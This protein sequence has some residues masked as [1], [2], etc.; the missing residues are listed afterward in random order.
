MR[1]QWFLAKYT[2]QSC[3]GAAEAITVAPYFPETIDSNMPSK[4]SP[5]ALRVVPADA[6]L[7][8][9]QQK[10]FNTLVEGIAKQRALLRDWEAAAL[11]FGHRYIAEMRP[12]AEHEQALKLQ[13]L[14]LLDRGAEQ[15]LAKADRQCVRDVICSLADEL[16]AKT[17]DEAQ[18]ANIKTI[19]NRHAEVDYDTE[20]EQLA[21]EDDDAARAMVKKVFGLDLE[22]GEDASPESVLRRLHEQLDAEQKSADA[23]VGADASKP[24]AGRPQKPS[25]SQRKAQEQAKEASQSVREIYRKLASAL[26]PDRETDA[27]ERERKTQLM[28]RVNQAYNAGN[29]LQ[30][31]ELQL[32]VEHI[33]TAHMAGLSDK[34]LRHYNRVL[35]EQLSELKQEIGDKQSQFAYS[36]QMPPFE[37]YT[38]KKIAQMLESDLSQA[39]Q[40]NSSLENLVDMLSEDPSTFK[41][42]LKEEREAQQRIAKAQRDG[43]SFYY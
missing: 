35:S 4:S 31:L 37:R 22:E 36:Y 6:V 38:P 33:D 41:H 20:Q 25:A 17:E 32:E 5:T 30:L 9:P 16:L 15:K 21:R 11:A 28:Q 23:A 18:A 2:R 40:E 12:L 3:F 19:F 26:H 34:R 29:L 39:A 24:A 13:L 14:H 1:Q 8:T 42:W 10:K 27:A 7:L 43:F